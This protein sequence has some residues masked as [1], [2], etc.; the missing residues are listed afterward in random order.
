MVWIA[1][2]RF[3]GVTVEALHVQ[4]F[5]NQ[6]FFMQIHDGGG[7]AAQREVSTDIAAAHFVFQETRHGQRS[8]AGACLQ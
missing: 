7:D 4:Q 8:A 6:A 5:A 3:R 1:G 2:Q